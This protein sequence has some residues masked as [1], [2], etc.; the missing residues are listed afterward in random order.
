M[1]YRA[2]W[3]GGEDHARRRLAGLARRLA[4]GD[5]RLR[6]PGRA[7][8]STNW[9]GSRTERAPRDQAGAVGGE[10]VEAG[11]EGRRRSARRRSC[12]VAVGVDG[13]VEHQGAHLVGEQLG[14][15][16]AERGAV[17][18]AEVGQLLVAERLAEPV[19]VP[20]GVD[21]VEGAAA[22]RRT[23]RRS[24]RRPPAV[25]REG[26][27]ELLVGR[28]P[29]LGGE[30]SRSFGRRRC[31]R[32]GVDRPDAAGVE[33][34]DVEAAAGPRSGSV[35][36]QAD[37]G[38][39]ARGARPAGVDHQRA[40]AVGLPG[41]LTTR[42]RN[43]GSVAPVGLVV[44]DRHLGAAALERQV[45]VAAG[46]RRRRAARICSLQSVQSIGAASGSAGAG[47]RGGRGLVAG[48]SSANEVQPART[49]PGR[50]GS[51]G[52]PAGRGADA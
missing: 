48:A 36:R 30:R 19:H 2:A 28:R 4:A 40:D 17:G 23:P 52:R 50:A 15:G 47:R 16:G 32:P 13:A 46:L 34:D 20:G 25:E 49:M 18:V 27:V 42:T 14:V 6:R 41:Q 1:S 9:R 12:A 45:A 39:G 5:R 44:A 43:S 35:E 10:G 22:R 3:I 24:R 26:V 8:R 31:T 21:G 7:G 29:R 37:G 11:L 51:Q 33:A 38:V